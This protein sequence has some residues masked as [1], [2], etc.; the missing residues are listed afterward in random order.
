MTGK[1]KIELLDL[2]VVLNYNYKNSHITNHMC[3][4][5]K[6][7]IMSPTY[8]SKNNCDLTCSV[9]QGKCKHLF[10]KRCLNSYIKAGNIV[11]PIDMTPWNTDHELDSQDTFKKLVKV[12]HA[13]KLNNPTL[14][15]I[16]NKK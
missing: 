1:A 2:H 6:C 7:H 10:H 12:Q 11:C 4:L 16:A 14:T 3:Q 9:V 5:C 8:E 15:C 13:G